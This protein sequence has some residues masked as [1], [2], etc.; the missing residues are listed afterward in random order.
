MLRKCKTGQCELSASKY[1]DCDCRLD[2]VMKKSTSLQ[3][4]VAILRSMF[5]N[6][7]GSRRSFARAWVIG[8]AAFAIGRLGPAV[9]E[10]DGLAIVQLGVGLQSKELLE[11][12]YV[13]ALVF[14][15]IANTFEHCSDRHKVRDQHPLCTGISG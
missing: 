6:D 2:E 10:S 14:E 15:I 9:T 12:W 3:S 4:T 13:I 11:I 1:A 8:A 5:G 7:F